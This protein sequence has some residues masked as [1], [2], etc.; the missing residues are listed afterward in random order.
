[1]FPISKSKQ[2]IQ[3]NFIIFFFNTFKFQNTFTILTENQ[4]KQARL[5]MLNYMNIHILYNVLNIMNINI[6]IKM[7]YRTY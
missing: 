1:M 2:I 4:M 6:F 3:Y 5:N 7:K